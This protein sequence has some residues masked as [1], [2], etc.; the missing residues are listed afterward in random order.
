MLG[1]EITLRNIYEVLGIAVGLAGDE[2]VFG[3][4]LD[5]YEDVGVALDMFLELPYVDQINYM[6]AACKQAKKSVPNV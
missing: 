4:T 5:E 1:K 2:E 6:M 3:K